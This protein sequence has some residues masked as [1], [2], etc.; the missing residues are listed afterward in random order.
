MVHSYPPL[1]SS[2]PDLT[3]P[4]NAAPGRQGRTSTDLTKCR[5]GRRLWRAQP[6]TLRPTPGETDDHT[7]LAGPGKVCVIGISRDAFAARFMH[8]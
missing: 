4:R 2:R 6:R 1:G 7:F 8:L 5:H 3:A